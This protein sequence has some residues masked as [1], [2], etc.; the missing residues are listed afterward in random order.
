MLKMTRGNTLHH[1]AA[2]MGNLELCEFFIEKIQEKDPRNKLGMIP[3]HFDRL[4]SNFKAYGRDVIE[5]IFDRSVSH[6]KVV[7][8][9][10]ATFR[11]TLT[12]VCQISR[13]DIKK[14]A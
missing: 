10:G 8:I 13:L 6:S 4:V 7:S 12:D 1:T 9:Q 5:T 14:G 11:H 3:L 2:Q